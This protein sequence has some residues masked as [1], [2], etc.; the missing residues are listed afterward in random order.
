MHKR[1][2]FIVWLFLHFL[3]LTAY[4]QEKKYT[5]SGHVRDQSSGENLPAAN[6]GILELKRGV[7]SNNYG[8]YSISVPPGKYNLKVSFLGFEP[9]IISVDIDKDLVLNVE[10]LPKNLVQKEIVIKDIRKDNNVK[11]TEMGMHQLS[12]ENVKKLPVI[13]GEVD[14]LKSLQ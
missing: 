3:F 9:Q 7:N 13:M 2:C 1:Y 6:V 12:M 4:S 14:V 11:S 8:F 10:L 5:I